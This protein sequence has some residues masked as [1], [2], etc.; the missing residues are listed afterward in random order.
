MLLKAP[1]KGKKGMLK[2]L[3]GTSLPSEDNIGE[4]KSTHFGSFGG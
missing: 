1:A 4:G 2:R 3:Y